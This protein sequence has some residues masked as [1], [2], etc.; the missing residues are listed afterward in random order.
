MNLLT[1]IIRTNF[2]IL[3]FVTPLLFTSFNSELFELP[4]MYFIYFLTLV[5]STAHLLN[6][7]N[8]KT[9]LFRR[10]F[11][12]IPL[13]IFLA[14]QTIST[15]TSIDPHTSFFGYYSRINGGLLSIICYLIL[16]FILNVYIDEFLTKKIISASLISGFLVAS[17]GITEHFG[18]D[19]HFWVQDVQSRVFSTLGQPNWLA[20]YL[21][22]LLPFS[23]FNFLNSLSLYGRSALRPYI[24]FSL[25]T[26]FFLCL[27]FTKSKSGIIA[28]AISLFIYFIFYAINNF[29]NKKNI[30]SLSFL[31]IFFTILSLTI[32]N[33][34][35]DQFF[36][37]QLKI[38]N[39]KIE[40]LNITS[41]QDIR[42]I[43]W[44]GSIDLW[45]KFP[46]F[47]TGVETFAYSYYWTRPA[48]HNLTSEWDFLYNKAHNEYLNFL[49]TTG[50]FGLLSY[51]LIIS[52]VLCFIFK[53]ILNTKY[54]ILNTI[55]SSY[56]SI[57]ITNFA[58]FSVAIVSIYFFLLPALISKDSPQKILIKKIK[59]SKFLSLIVIFL[60]FLSL[61]KLILFYL[62][63][64]VF[65]KSESSSDKQEYQ[66]AYDQIKTSVNFRPN[67][68]LYLNK[69]S[70]ASAKLAIIASSRKNTDLAGKLVAE[71]INNSNKSIEISPA[72]TSLWKE[73]AQTFYYL[74]TIDPKYFP[75]V[76]ESL[77]NVTKLAPTDAK[78]FY[79]LG[80]FLEIANST[81]ESI[82]YYQK[83][84]KLKPNYDY[85]LFDL[86]KIYFD[87]KN[88]SEAKKDFELVL[89]IAPTNKEAK[90]YLEKIGKLLK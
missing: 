43:V 84:I 40:N 76:I 16:F 42:K 5:I 35:K 34:I 50:T 4:K 8:Q 7:L 62:A 3:F 58:G 30:L 73:R 17:F 88:Y 81:E 41:S 56:I 60:F 33:P 37:P 26:I 19:K 80:K 29:K 57:L 86:G 27:L 83:A 67:E 20:A 46:F 63:D 52:C 90:D 18:I 32:N 79:L 12:N 48:G 28:A 44:K 6:F 65:A 55:L 74:S 14:S 85:A 10:H 69:L 64:I 59:Y 1:K 89:T 36:P 70:A 31:F 66:F 13:L 11:L 9:I 71:S 72:D 39:S 47:G 87:Q 49:A 15:I 25:T 75:T 53:N 21:C 23:I 82:K 77:I 38:E 68:P 2:L 78:T 22:I 61:Q 51:L 24:Y 54:L 45:K